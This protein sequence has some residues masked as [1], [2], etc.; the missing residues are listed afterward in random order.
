MKNVYS[1]KMLCLTEEKMGI[2][3][4]VSKFTF[5][6]SAAASESVPLVS[7]PESAP[8]L[9][10]PPLLLLELGPALLDVVRRRLVHSVD[11]VARDEEDEGAEADHHRAGDADRSAR[12]L[13]VL[14]FKLRALD[15]LLDLTQ[16][17]YSE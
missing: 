12:E 8:V 14:P 16:R 3:C 11:D 6:I 13:N 7:G 2:K 1:N 17:N 9:C 15:L 4:Y 5:S 10:R